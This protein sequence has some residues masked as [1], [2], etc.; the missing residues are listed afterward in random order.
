MRAAVFMAIRTAQTTMGIVQGEAR[1]MRKLA[2]IIKIMFL[3]MA[4]FA[5]ALHRAFVHIFVTLDASLGAAE[6]TQFT[7]GQYRLI[8][9]RMT[10]GAAQLGVAPVQLIVDRA[11]VKAFRTQQ[12]GQAEAA[13]PA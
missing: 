6:V 9:M 1:V 5:A 7:F 11:V 13:R 8:R 12:T 4:F 10:I 3:P 2:E